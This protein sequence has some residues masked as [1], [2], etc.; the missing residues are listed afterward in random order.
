VTKL[1]AEHL[2][3]LYHRNFGVPTVS[4]RYF[5]V[6][7]PRQR[8]DMAFNR[9]IRAGLKSEPV[10]IFGDGT[11]TRDFTY[12]D[13]TVEC[14]VRALESGPPGEVLNVGG[15][16]RVTLN[17]ALST[18]E[19]VLHV[20]LDRRYEDRARGDVTDTLADSARAESELGFRPATP[21]S[22]GLA[23]QAEWMKGIEA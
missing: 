21:L 15:G 17:E 5:T 13:D 16:S 9:F 3:V 2:A 11:Q 14:T 19:D 1:A 8:P 22:D 6:Y 4:L 10:R 23:M 20:R 7:G 18:I 12:V